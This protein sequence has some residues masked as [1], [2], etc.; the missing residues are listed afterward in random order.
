MLGPL[1]FN[2]YIS[3]DEVIQGMF[4]KFASGNK[5]GGRIDSENGYQE[6]VGP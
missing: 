4:S 5:V 1:L 3:L 6:L 2:I